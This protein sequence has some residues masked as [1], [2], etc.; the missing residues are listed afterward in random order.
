MDLL[1]AAVLVGMEG[2]LVRPRLRW[3]QPLALMGRLAILQHGLLEGH[4]VLA[5]AMVRQVLPGQRWPTS[6]MRADLGAA[7]GMAALQPMAGTVEQGASLAAVAAVG[8]LR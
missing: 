4:P 6:P 1:S 8:L 5:A 2:A 7:A 3:A